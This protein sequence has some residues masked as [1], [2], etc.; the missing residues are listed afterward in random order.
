V[1]RKDFGIDLNMPLETGGVVLGDKVT[2][3]LDMEALKSA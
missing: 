3:T 1:N 2:V